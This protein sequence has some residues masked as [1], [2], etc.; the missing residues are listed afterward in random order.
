MNRALLLAV[1][2]AGCAATPRQETTC[3]DYAISL[4]ALASDRSAGLLTPGEIQR[5]DALRPYANLY[6]SDEVLS[7]AEQQ[8]LISIVDELQAMRHAE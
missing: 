7:G 6:C 1:L 8:R 4:Q 5:V 2:L 3:L